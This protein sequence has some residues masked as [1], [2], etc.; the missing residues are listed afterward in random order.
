MLKHVCAHACEHAYACACESACESVCVLVC[1]DS[2]CAHV[3]VCAGACVRVR[4][5]VRVC[6]RA[7]A[8][9]VCVCGP[10]RARTHVRA[11][12]WRHT[13]RRR[14][15][16]RQS[17]RRSGAQ[18]TQQHRRRASSANGGVEVDVEA[19][20]VPRAAPRE[21]RVDHSPVEGLPRGGGGA[22]ARR[23]VNDPR[24]GRRAVVAALDGKRINFFD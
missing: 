2:A 21:G 6:V 1:S 20:G 15:R 13:R 19:G 9:S 7:H 5:C 24:R 22:L 14:A 8:R 10:A 23:C 4:V 3:G 16:N 12:A 18:G 17:R 11:A